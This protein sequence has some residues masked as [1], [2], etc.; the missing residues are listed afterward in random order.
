MLGG[1]EKVSYWDEPEVRCG[2]KD[3]CGAESVQ[4]GQS[5]SPAWVDGTRM[6]LHRP[7][8]GMPI[9]WRFGYTKCEYFQAYHSHV[10]EQLSYSASFQIN[11][12]PI[13]FSV[14]GKPFSTLFCPYQYSLNANFMT[15]SS[16]QYE[17]AE[18][19]ILVWFFF[20]CH[21]EFCYK[22]SPL[23]TTDHK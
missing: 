16:Y 20:F 11:R 12:P 19:N 8:A 23:N 10:S 4:R 7:A 22:Y 18:N 5:A 1:E 17:G 9:D 13:S 2:R 3:D 14:N 21:S 15:W 6:T